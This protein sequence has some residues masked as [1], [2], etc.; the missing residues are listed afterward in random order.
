[1]HMHMHMF[2]CMYMLHVATGKYMSL[3]RDPLEIQFKMDD[4]NEPV[5]GQVQKRKLAEPLTHIAKP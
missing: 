5:R 1:M 3:G 2:M 4:G